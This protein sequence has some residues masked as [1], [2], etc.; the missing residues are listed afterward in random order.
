MENLDSFDRRI[1]GL[2]RTNSRRT[3]EQLSEIIGLSSAAC[4]RRV[5]RLR[6]IGAIEREVAIISPKFENRG[7]TLLVLLTIDRHNPKLMDDFCHHLRR[8][9]EVERLI[10]VTGEDDIVVILDCA[11]MADF[12]DFCE[13][14]FEDSPVEGYKTLVSLREYQTEESG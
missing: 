5:Q 7:T 4:L 8:Q 6:N 12:A 11:S 10:W 2:L 9:R 1:L 13:I 3:G 14:H